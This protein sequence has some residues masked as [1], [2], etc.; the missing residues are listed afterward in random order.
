MR[1]LTHTCPGPALAEDADSRRGA[2]LVR[3]DAG[4]QRRAGG[5][6]SERGAGSRR[7]RGIG[8]RPALPPLIGL[9]TL[10]ASARVLWLSAAGMAGWVKGKSF[11]A[12]GLLQGQVAIV[13]GG[14]TGIGKAIVKALGAG[15]GRE[16]GA[17]GGAWGV[18]SCRAERGQISSVVC[19]LLSPA[20]S[21]ITGESVDVYGGQCLFSHWYEFPDHDNWPEGAGDLSVVKKMKASFKQK[22]KP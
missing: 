2:V 5:A 21:F 19:F 11:L 22:A 3:K 14:A 17:L 12:P 4:L 10:G 8:P 20:A 16:P 1:S 15:Y 13:T 7:S 6:G 9:R 18:W